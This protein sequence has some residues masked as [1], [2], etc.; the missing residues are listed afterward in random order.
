[1]EALKE[2]K[3]LSDLAQKFDVQAQQITTRKAHY[4]SY[5]DSI[6][7]KESSSPK[8][9]DSDKERMYYFAPSG[10]RK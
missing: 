4:I 2:R 6:V 9:Q 10:S 5:A 8:E 3:T 7:E 1:M